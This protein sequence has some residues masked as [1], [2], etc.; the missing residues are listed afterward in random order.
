MRK[1][2]TVLAL[3][4]GGGAGLAQEPVPAERPASAYIRIVQGIGGGCDAFRHNADA[5]NA[6]PS[7]AIRATFRWPGSGGGRTSVHTL[8]PGEKRTITYC[9][10]GELTLAGARFLD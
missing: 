4:I 9:N 3:L 6:H 8:E 1:A 10:S 5:E 7:R 2:A